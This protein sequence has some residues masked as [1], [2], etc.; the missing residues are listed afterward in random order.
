MSAPVTL[1]RADAINEGKVE[2]TVDGVARTPGRLDILINMA[3]L[4]VS[5]PNPTAADWSSGSSSGALPAR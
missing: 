2:A 1:I 4:Y 5:A 3:S